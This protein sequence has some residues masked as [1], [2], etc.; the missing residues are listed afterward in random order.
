MSG[1]R[2]QAGITTLGIQAKPVIPFTYFDP[3]AKV[4]APPLH[5]SAEWLHLSS[6]RGGA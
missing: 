2:A 4:D 5:G 1:A 3:I 6:L